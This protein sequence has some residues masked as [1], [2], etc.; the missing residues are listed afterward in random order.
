MNFLEKQLLMASTSTEGKEK[1]EARRLQFLAQR[2]YYEPIKEGQINVPETMRFY[3]QDMY[4]D[5]PLREE[6]KKD[7]STVATKGS[8][9]L[10][11]RF[12]AKH[13]RCRKQPD[14]AELASMVCE[15]R[16]ITYEKTDDQWNSNKG[17][18]PEFFDKFLPCYYGLTSRRLFNIDEVSTA[19]R[20]GK[21][22]VFQVADSLNRITVTS[23]D[24]HYIVVVGDDANGFFIYDPL[25][26]SIQHMNHNKIFKVLIEAWVVYRI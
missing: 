21:L 26:T 6:Y 25:Y 20:D 17:I 12:C 9:I 24:S 5:I 19:I 16:Y 14:V 10:V 15:L 4:D 11:A 2:W 13:Y 8:G 1:Q 3:A 23:K 7:D 18:N 22:L